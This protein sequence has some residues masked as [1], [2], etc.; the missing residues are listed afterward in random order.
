MCNNKSDRDTIWWPKSLLGCGLL[1]ILVFSSTRCLELSK[2]GRQV[3]AQEEYI[4]DIWLTS[5]RSD[6]GLCLTVSSRSS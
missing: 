2:E 3:E 1:C 4:K 5:T 6:D